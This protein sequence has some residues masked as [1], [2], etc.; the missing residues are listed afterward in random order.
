[1]AIWPCLDQK[2][3]AQEF[4]LGNTTLSQSTSSTDAVRYKSGELLAIIIGHVEQ[5]ALQ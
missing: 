5:G 3:L 2:S 1:M 4:G